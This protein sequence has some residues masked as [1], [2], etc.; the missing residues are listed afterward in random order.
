MQQE[1]LF[2]LNTFNTMDDTLADGSLPPSHLKKVQGFEYAEM[3][4][5]K[6]VQGNSVETA[7][8]TLYSY[9][10]SVDCYW[11]SDGAG[12]YTVYDDEYLKPDIAAIKWTVDSIT[13]VECT[14]NL[15][16]A[17]GST[18]FVGK[19]YKTTT[20]TWTEA[21]TSPPAY[22]ASSYV[23]INAT[24]PGVT[25]SV[26]LPNAWY[27][28]D[29]TVSIV[30]V[31]DS[32]YTGYFDSYDTKL[33][34]SYLSSALSYWKLNEASGDALN[35][36]SGGDA[37]TEV[38]TVGFDADGPFNACRNGFSSSNYFTLPH[39]AAYSKT[40]LAIEGWFKTSDSSYAQKTMLQKLNGAYGWSLETLDYSKIRFKIDSDAVDT[41][42]TFNDG[43]WH[44]IFAGMR[45][46]SGSQERRIY[47]DNVLIATGDGRTVTE[48]SNTGALRLGIDSLTTDAYRWEGSLTGFVFHDDIS[49]LSWIDIESYIANVYKSGLGKELGV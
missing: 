42:E 39:D 46:T 9:E 18:P 28:T 44:Y 32:G 23:S 38:G 25:Y 22:D 19:I 20:D 35:S 30:I 43:D 41:T 31:P 47:I 6:G 15:T 16:L 27:T 33:Y 14:L 7:T 37:L 40:T 3:G 26:T 13:P 36:K 48:A 8:T 2:S 5:I 45:D 17:R 24:T 11:V 4:A 29:I 1:E 49:S 21:S 12:G 34:V 10:S